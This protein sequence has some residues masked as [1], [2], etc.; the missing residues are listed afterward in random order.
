M[1]YF[2]ISIMWCMVVTHGVRVTPYLPYSWQLFLS[3]MLVE[4]CDPLLL[5]FIP[6]KGKAK[7]GGESSNPWA[8]SIDSV[9]GRLSRSYFEE[10]LIVSCCGCLY[11][12]LLALFCIYTYIPWNPV[13]RL[14]LLC[15]LR[16]WVMFSLLVSFACVQVILVEH[17]WQVRVASLLFH[18]LSRDFARVTSLIER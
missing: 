9:Q 18:Y 13:G 12:E 8:I 17:A 5:L 7:C 15:M 3:Y 4:S 10:Y 11:F 14:S 6:G 16:M 2:S 1:R